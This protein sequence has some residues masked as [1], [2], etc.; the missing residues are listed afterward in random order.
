M[1]SGSIHGILIE[2]ILMKAP[3]RFRNVNHIVN[4]LVMAWVSVGLLVPPANGKLLVLHAHDDWD[5][6]GHLVELINGGE[7]SEDHDQQH[8]QGGHAGD[9]GIVVNLNAPHGHSADGNTKPGGLVIS[10]PHQAYAQPLKIATMRVE[11][12]PNDIT[13]ADVADTTTGFT[14]SDPP[15]DG[16]VRGGGSPHIIAR[17]LQGS[18]ALLF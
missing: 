4:V 14:C 9:N 1:G 13:V 17:I 7:L 3:K 15:R 6:H 16:N 2:S 10:L 11:P 5:T 8:C 12:V 18:H